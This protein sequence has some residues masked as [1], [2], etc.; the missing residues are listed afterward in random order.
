[1][2]PI[3]IIS[4]RFARASARFAS[5]ARR[6]TFAALEWPSIRMRSSR[7]WGV[8]S[9]PGWRRWRSPSLVNARM[10]VS[11]NSVCSSAI[12]RPFGRH[13]TSIP[14]RSVLKGLVPFLLGKPCEQLG[15]RSKLGARDGLATV[16]PV[17]Q[18]AFADLQSGGEPLA[19]HEAACAL[20]DV[21]PDLEGL[22]RGSRHPVKLAAFAPRRRD[23]L[24]TGR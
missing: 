9:V 19:P 14:C 24:H 13:S 5:R 8:S 10:R 16:D 3:A 12:G 1:M 17:P 4:S 7:C 6:T 2:Y 15:Q 20:Q 22:F 18:F 11:S 21:L 23:Y